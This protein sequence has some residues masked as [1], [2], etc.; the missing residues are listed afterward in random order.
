M[1]GWGTARAGQPIWEIEHVKGEAADLH[2]APVALGRRAA[3]VV[4]VTAPAVVL[5]S[6]QRVR[7]GLADASAVP[8]VRRHSGGGAVWVEPGDPVW[9]DVVVPVGDPLWE[10]DVGRAFW[11]LGECWAAALVELGI[12]GAEVHRGPITRS[13]WSSSVCFGGLGAGE[14]TVGGRKVVGM[15]QRRQRAGALF[16]CAVLR[17]WSPAALTGALGIPDAAADLATVATG[18]GDADIVTAFLRVLQAV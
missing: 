8:F 7:P 13:Q 9:V 14:V 4:E 2:A 11:W 3:R 12:A 5:G 18:I 15:A 17:R 10:A 1:G 16:Q 6:A